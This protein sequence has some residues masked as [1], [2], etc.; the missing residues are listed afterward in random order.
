MHIPVFSEILFLLVN[1]IHIFVLSN[2]IENIKLFLMNI[3]KIIW[4]NNFLC[5]HSLFK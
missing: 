4:Y 1:K 2:Y 5:V 3:L